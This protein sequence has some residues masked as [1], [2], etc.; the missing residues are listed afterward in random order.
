[1]PITKEPAAFTIKTT[2]GMNN[3]TEE[4][5]LNGKWVR[6][7]LNC[8]FEDEPGAVTK[9]E[10]VAFFNS[11]PISGDGGILG[12]Y[13]YYGRTFI[14]TLAA[15]DDGIYVGDDVAG[16]FTQIRSMSTSGNRVR[17]VTY[18]DLAIGFS[19]QEVPFVYDGSDDDVTWE[20]GACKAIV[21]GGTGITATAISYKITY[22][23]D[24]YIPDT[25]SNEINSVTNESIE[26]S[27][28]PVGPPGTL[29][30]K[31]YRKD[32]LSGGAWRELATIADNFT[33]TFT[34]TTATVAGNPVI[35]GATD[36]MPVGDI[37]VITRERLFFAGDPDEPNR[38]YFSNP[39]LP[40]YIQH[41]TNLDFLDVAKDDGDE[42]TGLAIQLGTLQCFKRNTIRKV[43][44]SSAQSGADP[45]TWFAEDPISFVGS[46]AKDSIVQTPYGIIFLGWDRWYRYDGN[47]ATP[48]IDEFNTR[49]ILPA[50]YNDVVAHYTQST[51]FASYS[52][53]ETASQNSDRVM[54]YN[55]IRNRF[56]ID[57]LSISA[58]S[59]HEG[60]DE[61]GELFYGS[62]VEGTVLKAEE[63]DQIFRLSTRTQALAGTQDNVFVGGTEVSPY[64]EIG[65]TTAALAI[66][67][68][69]CILWDASDGNPGPGW[70]DVTATYDGNFLK[71]DGTFG[72]FDSGTGHTH[73]ISGTTNNNTDPFTP[74]GNN[75]DGTMST[76][77]HSHTFSGASDSEVAEPRHTVLRIFKKNNS[78]TETE[79]PIGSIVMFDQS[80]TPVGFTAV[81][82]AIGHY[83]KF[84]VPSSPFEEI[85][86]THSHTFTIL[87]SRSTQTVAGWNGGNHTQPHRHNIVG[88]TSASSIDTWELDYVSFKFLKKTGESD[89]WDG[90][91]NFVYTLFASNVA[92]T[93]GWAEDTNYSGRFLKIGTGAPVTGAAAN[94]SHTHTYP[95][96]VSTIRVTGSLDGGNGAESNNNP[97]NHTHSYPGGV[98]SSGDADD[99]PSV[100][101][102]LIRKVLGQM[103]DY[104]SAITSSE[105]EGVWESPAA[106]INAQ[107]LKVI[108]WNSIESGSDLLEVFTRTASTMAGVEDATALTSVDFTTDTFTLVSHGLVD[109]DRVRIGGTAVPTGI[110]GNL[111]YHVVGSTGS[112]FQVSLTQ[113]GGAV[114]FSDNGT[115]VTFKKWDLNVD[116]DPVVSSANVW[117]QY[118][119]AFT[120]TDTTVTNP[121][122]FSSD[123][124]ML[125]FFYERGGVI[126]E[127]SVDFVY[128]TGFLNFDQP[129]QDKLYNK[130]NIWHEG[131]GSYTFNWFTEFS[132][133]SMNVDM[134]VAPNTMRW[135]SFF[136]DTAFGRRLRASITKSDLL[137]LTVKE[138]SGLYIPEPNII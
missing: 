133:D 45:N 121:R 41:V 66:P 120:A 69:V 112:T 40:H 51:L 79:F 24:A 78:T 28:I 113:G 38:I 58:F 19:R 35:S 129:M 106:E 110:N 98:S 12:L 3:K 76:G 109:N 93:N 6:L 99:P 135:D 108:E 91:S 29:N 80:A 30:R 77:L 1:M 100:T 21:G 54:V 101:F 103:K 68:D 47:Q 56:S 37:P 67:E 96:G 119:L 49:T 23:A 26:L 39:F 130:I 94:A 122:I 116:M 61:S 18:Q 118:L 5:E 136:Q 7:A 82:S 117:I 65:S 50:N 70:D 127:T 90:V 81:S 115:A 107:T 42:I 137:P 87:T 88:T 105:T 111:I 95:S 25:V 11:T 48:F 32:S 34:D 60:D 75:T 71:L 62:S 85:F 4:L 102:R 128:D 63:S 92:P 46:P 15:F 59:S 104:N 33:T 86:P 55:F 114:D 53:L 64:I 10:P 138:I 72:T 123:L 124:Y 43:Y 52:A 131:S 125:R 22:D 36:E 44:I 20:L 27:N 17:W 16:S 31:I 126:A 84:G 89:T 14:K 97:F 74:K 9:R 134:D 83:V 132:S 8:R 73:N 13:R 57:T 2:P